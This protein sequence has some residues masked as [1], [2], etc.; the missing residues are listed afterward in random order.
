MNFIITKKAI[1]AIKVKLE[2]KAS[3]NADLEF[4]LTEEGESVNQKAWGGH[5]RER[6]VDPRGAKAGQ[7]RGQLWTL[8]RGLSVIGVR[9]GKSAEEEASIA[10]RGKPLK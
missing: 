2:C 9:R 4:A 6:T 7:D 8:Q 10:F 3:K 1:D 5:P